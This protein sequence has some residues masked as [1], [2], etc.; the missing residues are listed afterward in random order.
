MFL[1]DL[2]VEIGLLIDCVAYLYHHN[3]SQHEVRPVITTIV[4][5]D[6]TLSKPI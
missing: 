5:A 3:Q 6:T 4:D 2:N 1:T